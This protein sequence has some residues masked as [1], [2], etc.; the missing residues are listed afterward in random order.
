MPKNGDKKRPLKLIK[1]LKH[2]ILYSRCRHNYDSIPMLTP[3]FGQIKFE[4][5]FSNRFAI[6][7]TGGSSKN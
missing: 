3:S 6:K 5:T 1:T 4:I 2:K 7:K